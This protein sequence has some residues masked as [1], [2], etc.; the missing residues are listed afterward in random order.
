M[1]LLKDLINTIF[2]KDHQFVGGITMIGTIIAYLFLSKVRTVHIDRRRMLV[3]SFIDN[4]LGVSSHSDPI[5][6]ACIFLNRIAT[7]K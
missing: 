2:S 4:F 6:A 1:T 7:Q 5:V 3:Y